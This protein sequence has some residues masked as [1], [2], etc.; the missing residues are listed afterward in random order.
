MGVEKIRPIANVEYTEGIDGR[1]A[2]Y[3]IEYKCPKCGR[4]IWGYKSKTACDQC[5]TFYDWGKREPSIEI[6]RSVRW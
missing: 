5:G 6:K 4:V 3:Y 1:D 2:H